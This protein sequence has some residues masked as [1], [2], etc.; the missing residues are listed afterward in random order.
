MKRISMIVTAAVALALIAAVL[1]N[2]S[3]SNGSA[4]TAFASRLLGIAGAGSSGIQ[5]QNLSTTGSANIVADFYPQSGGAKIPL[6][7]VAGPG[8]AAN[9]YLP[10]ESAL[11]DGAYAV[12]VSA[13]QLI[14]AIARTDWGSS[15]GAAIYGSVPP[16]S[17]VLVPLVVR[18]YVNQYTMLSVQNTDTTASANVTINILPRGSSTPAM[19]VSASIGPGTSKTWDI[20]SNDFIGLP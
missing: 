12:V 15:G 13:D 11:T 2:G 9:F 18:A 5:V 4:H 14:G 17:S 19:T 10:G 16:A 6:T 8:A 20:N 7:R 3:L 1:L